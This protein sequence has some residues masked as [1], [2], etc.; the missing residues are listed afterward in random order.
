MRFV[1]L[2]RPLLR[3]VRSHERLYYVLWQVVAGLEASGSTVAS[4]SIWCTT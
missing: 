1:D 3:V 2:P 4:D